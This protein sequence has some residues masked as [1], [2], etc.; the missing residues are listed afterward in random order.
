[1]TLSDEF[2]NELAQERELDK[3][4]LVLRI[5]NQ[6]VKSVLKDA[7]NKHLECKGTIHLNGEEKEVSVSIDL[8]HDKKSA[9]KH[10][11]ELN[12]CYQKKW[13]RYGCC[14]NDVIDALVWTIVRGFVSGLWQDGWLG[15]LMACGLVLVLLVFGVPF[16]ALVMILMMIALPFILLYSKL[17]KSKKPNDR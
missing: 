2:M 15:K 6:L 5:D 16:I 3:S 9:K 17:F 7:H 10:N 11:V 12:E 8:S 4:R 14:R 13:Q 1:M